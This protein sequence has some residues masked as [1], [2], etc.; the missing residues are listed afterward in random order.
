MSSSWKIP[1][2]SPIVGVADS[3]AE[4]AIERALE[5]AVSRPDER[6]SARSIKEAIAFCVLMKK[7][8][9][10]L[11]VTGEEV[12]VLVGEPEKKEGKLSMEFALVHFEVDQPDYSE[13]GMGEGFSQ[14]IPPHGFLALAMR[15]IR[16]IKG[17]A[18]GDSGLIREKADLAV[19]GLL[20]VVASIPLDHSSVPAEAFGDDD[21]YDGLS[22]EKKAQFTRVELVRLIGHV[23]AV[24]ATALGT[25]K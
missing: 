19:H 8:V 21:F 14:L 10:A 25:E 2:L 22:P 6:Y 23:R 17:A 9:V 20:D 18:K 7:V 12:E 15:T 1:R 4:E 5:R 24:E 3:A 13:D 11:R 16:E